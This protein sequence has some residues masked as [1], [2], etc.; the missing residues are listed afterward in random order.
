[1]I[2]GLVKRSRRRGQPRGRLA[3]V[4]AT[5]QWTQRQRSWATVVIT[6]CAV[7]IFLSVWAVYAASHTYDRY[8]QLDAG[9]SMKLRTTT[10]RVLKMRQSKVVTDGGRD[11]PARANT[12]WVIADMRIIV[13]KKTGT[14]CTDLDLVGPGKRTWTSNSD[15]F[16]RKMPTYCNDKIRVDQ[17]FHYQLIYEVPT[18]FVDKIYGIGVDDASSS[19]PTKVLRP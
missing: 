9:A 10:Y 12:R 19:K 3:R 18:K 5:G 2:S 15:F 11:H 13:S 6:L 16:H 1:M 7:L 14:P 17:P 8:R 4:L